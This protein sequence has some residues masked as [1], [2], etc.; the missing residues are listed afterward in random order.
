MVVIGF[1]LGRTWI[2]AGNARKR[3]HLAGIDPRAVPRSARGLMSGAPRGPSLRVRDPSRPRPAR[4]PRIDV[5][6]AAVFLVL[7]LAQ[8]AVEPIAAPALSVVVAVGSTVPLAWR[9]VYPAT[10]ALADDR[11]LAD[12]DVGRGSCS[13]A[14]SSPSWCSSPSARR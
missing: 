5:V 1:L 14:T 8:V 7:S 12:P 9:R 3:R 4:P 13:S 10:A 2:S 11:G 6:L